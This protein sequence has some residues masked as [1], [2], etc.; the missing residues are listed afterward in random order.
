MYNQQKFYALTT[1]HLLIHLT[2]TG[3]YIGCSWH[4]VA[5]CANFPPAIS[6]CRFLLSKSYHMQ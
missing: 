4:Q 2:Q 3:I 6:C 1:T 5:M